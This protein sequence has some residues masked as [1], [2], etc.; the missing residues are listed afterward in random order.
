MN[1]RGEPLPEIDVFLGDQRLRLFRDVE[2]FLGSVRSNELQQL[3]TQAG[4]QRCTT[5][6]DGAFEFERPDSEHP[7]L[8]VAWSAD[9]GGRGLV[10]P[11]DG[12]L[13]IVL[14]VDAVVSGVVRSSADGA[15]I[16]DA[17]VQLWPAKSGYPIAFE[18]T[19][20]RGAYEL[21]RLPPGPTA[22][23]SKAR[24]TRNTARSSPSSSARPSST[25]TSSWIRSRCSARSS[26]TPKARRG[27]W[28][29]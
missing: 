27:R 8:V 17:K 11:A 21:Q 12:D 6:P 10:L 28:R 5:D 20:A 15:P 26:S 13:E 1:G 25:W 24:A 29:V 19:D 18:R 9:R 7:Q 16:E 3:A 2:Q 4:V 23:R 14:P 22:P